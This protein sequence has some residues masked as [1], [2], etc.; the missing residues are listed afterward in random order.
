MLHTHEFSISSGVSNVPERLSTGIRITDRILISRRANGR[1]DTTLKSQIH[2]NVIE[3]LTLLRCLI[4]GERAI[5]LSLSA[6]RVHGTFE[7]GE[8][9]WV[10]SRSAA[11]SLARFCAAVTS[12]FVI[13]SSMPSRCCAANCREPSHLVGLAAAILSHAYASSKFLL[14]ILKASWPNAVR[15]GLST[16]KSLNSPLNCS[17]LRRSKPLSFR[18]YAIILPEAFCSKS[19]MMSVI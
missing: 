6:V 17:T 2:V 1:A 4:D 13:C 7:K 18:K 12:D 9:A 8:P 3:G 16:P 11:S 19:L 15:V 5:P 10:S 14:R